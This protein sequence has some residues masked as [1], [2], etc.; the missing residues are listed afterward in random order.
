VSQYGLL[1]YVGLME[2]RLCRRSSS[3][4]RERFRGL[5]G[6]P[7]SNQG[8]SDLEAWRP[9]LIGPQSSWG[10]NRVGLRTRL[11]VWSVEV[12]VSRHW[13][14]PHPLLLPRPLPLPPGRRGAEGVGSVGQNLVGPRRSGPLVSGKVALGHRAAVHFGQGAWR[15]GLTW[16][17]NN[18][19]NNDDEE[20]D[21]NRDL[22]CIK[23]SSRDPPPPLTGLHILIH[24]SFC[25]INDVFL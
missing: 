15:H 3:S 20:Q 17:Q 24:L 1:R 5:G 14:R 11:P 23:R 19:N 13:R 22:K 10:R 4:T 16:V 9:A 6:T 25:T 18:N 7:G 21:K 12:E 2:T 8:G